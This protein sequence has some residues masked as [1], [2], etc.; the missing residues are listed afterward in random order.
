MTLSGVTRRRSTEEWRNVER[1][2]TSDR[3]K[4]LAIVPESVFNFAGIPNLRHSPGRWAPVYLAGDPLEL[5]VLILGLQSRE[6]VENF[7]DGDL[8]LLPCGIATCDISPTK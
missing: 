5:S 2:V 8:F 3:R 7:S 6:V 1:W 4:P